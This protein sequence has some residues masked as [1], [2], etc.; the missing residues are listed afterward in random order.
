M[1]GNCGFGYLGFQWPVSRGGSQSPMSTSSRGR[2]S[3]ERGV[4]S[5]LSSRRELGQGQREVLSVCVE[6][7][8]GMG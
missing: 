7:S 5:A 6:H 4:K 8:K 1:E 3:R 2:S